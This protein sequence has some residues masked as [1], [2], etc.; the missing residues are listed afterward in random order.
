MNILLIEV[1]AASKYA[2]NGLA[3]LSG[4]LSSCHKARVFDLNLLKWDERE[5]LKRSVEFNPDII[6]FSIK[7]SNIIE[8]NRLAVL[9][10]E[11]IKKAVLVAGGPHITLVGVDFFNKIGSLFDYGF[12]GESETNFAEFCDKFSNNYDVRNVN[13]LVYNKNGQWSV[14][15]IE[16]NQQL[17]NINFPDYSSFVGIDYSV[18]HYPLLTSRGCP[19]Q[20]IYCSVNKISGRR[21]RYRSPQSVILELK[22][23]KEK[24]GIKYFSILDD[25]FTLNKQRAIDIC[26]LLIKENINLKWGCPNGLRADSLDIEL[27]RKMKQAGCDSVSIGIESG[28]KKIFDFINKGETLYDIKMAINLLREEQIKTTGF[29]IVGL[30]YD[31]IRATKNT[32][33]FLK[34]LNIFGG[35]KWNMLVPYPKTFIWSWVEKNGRFLIDFTKSRHFNRNGIV[36]DPTF[37]TIEFSAKQRKR[38]F[39]LANIS[40]GNYHMV[41][42]RTNSRFFYK[43]K[44]VFY[45]LIYNPYFLVQKIIDKL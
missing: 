10:S 34:S 3:Y 36:V 6:G 37:E 29:L 40:T 30:P 17:D 2:H 26:D 22:Q 41:M 44:I 16:Y 43:L 7:S 38:A 11:K 9:L 45:M 42:R 25:N 28:D 39:I 31:S 32:L 33:K 18:I 14:N 4:S 24:Y 20:C 19:Y 21:W 15:S 13:G 35:F 8:V 27:V 23:A 5:F 12:I 1:K